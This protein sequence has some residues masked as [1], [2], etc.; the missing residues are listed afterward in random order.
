MLYFFSSNIC[1]GHPLVKLHFHHQILHRMFE[2]TLM[3]K[4]QLK[5]YCI[6][7]IVR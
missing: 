1:D 3:Y 5:L 7:I 6:A 2:K 4:L